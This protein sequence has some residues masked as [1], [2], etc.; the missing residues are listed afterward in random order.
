MSPNTQ[1]HVSSL[2]SDL[3]EMAEATRKLPEL[4]RSL[5]EFERKSRED[6]ERIARLEQKLMEAAAREDE[7]KAKLRSVEAERD[8]AGFRQLEAEDK[9]ADLRRTI[10]NSFAAMGQSLAA[11]NGDGK[12]QSVRMSAIEVQE[13]AEHREEKRRKVEE[14]KRQAEEAVRQAE[15]A[16]RKAEEEAQRQAEAQPV[17]AS[18]NPTQPSSDGSSNGGTSAIEHHEAPEVASPSDPTPAP[19][20]EPVN[21]TTATSQ[22]G[23]SEPQRRGKYHGIKYSDWPYYVSLEGW[24]AG[25]GTEE[26]YHWR[27]AAQ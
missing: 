11:V 25:G 8:D 12:D 14:A 10:E 18:Q 1:Q 16:K 24:L 7:L 3:V 23:A 17:E 15:E 21:S 2:V 13:F 20:Q 19:T 26:D 9:L 6:G 5:E 22:V 27:P 4:Q